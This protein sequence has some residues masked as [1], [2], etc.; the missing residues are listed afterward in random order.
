MSNAVSVR[1]KRQKDL[2]IYM[3]MNGEKLKSVN[4]LK[5]NFA[6]DELID[7]YYSGE[8][9]YFPRKTGNLDMVRNISKNNAFLLVKL[10]EILEIKP[11][12]SEEE[13]R[14]SAV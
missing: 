14:A 5:K 2:M 13:V 6:I 9:E 10:Y 4:D 7:S 8:L 12:L 3:T 1:S 11:E